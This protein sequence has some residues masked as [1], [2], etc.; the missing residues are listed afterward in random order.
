MRISSLLVLLA[1]CFAFPPQAQHGHGGGG[2]SSTSPR[3]SS[4]SVHVRGYTTRSGKTV[5]HYTRNA[6]G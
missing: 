3:S 6:P 5:Q 1:A 2:H 4:G